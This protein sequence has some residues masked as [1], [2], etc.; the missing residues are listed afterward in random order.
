[1]IKRVVFSSQAQ[2]DLAALDR[3]VAIRDP[4]RFTA[5]LKQE[6]VMSRR[7]H[8]T[9]PPEFRL[10]VGHWRVRFYDHAEGIEIL[11]VK[12]RSQAY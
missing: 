6:P 8:G 12:H 4:T 10:R 11:R 9:H 1:M 2:A 7:F 3:A 5:S